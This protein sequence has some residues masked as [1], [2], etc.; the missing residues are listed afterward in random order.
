MA[1]P[2]PC[3]RVALIQ[4]SVP[5]DSTPATQLQRVT[6]LIIRAAS[7]NADLAV[8]PEMFLG[9]TPADTE[10]KEEFARQSE[11]ALSQFQALAKVSL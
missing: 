8:L 7:N 4:I 3:S 6:D 11:T 10:G 9:W 2:L 1:S 5:A